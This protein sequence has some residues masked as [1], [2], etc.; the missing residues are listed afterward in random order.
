MMNRITI[1]IE[2][3][4][5]E[6]CVKTVSEGISKVKGVKTV[7]VDLKKGTATVESDGASEEDIV[8]AVLDSGFK[9]KVKHGLFK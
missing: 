5:C 3:M 2:G 7:E 4:M 1:K 8:M 6:S 9:A